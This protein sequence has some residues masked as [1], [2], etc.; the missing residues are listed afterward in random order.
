MRNATLLGAL[1]TTI[2]ALT[3]C[4]DH[5]PTEPSAVDL[6]AANYACRNNPMNPAGA[7]RVI[8]SPDG[9][10]TDTTPVYVNRY[11]EP[12]RSKDT[13]VTTTSIGGR[14]LLIFGHGGDTSTYCITV[15]DSLNY[16]APNFR[17]AVVVP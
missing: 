5:G 9:V 1:L 17:G 12:H 16:H 6:P 8:F 3:A 13:V 10:R 14:L 4:R 15:F 7:F 11:L 2:A